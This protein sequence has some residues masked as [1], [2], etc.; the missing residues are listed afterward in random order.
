MCYA[1][2]CYA[3]LVCNID[4]KSVAS[5]LQ[6]VDFPLAS[7]QQVST[8]KSPLCLLCCF[9]SQIPLQRLVADKLAASPSKGKLRG[10]V[11]NGL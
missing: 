10:N 9:V 8:G 5:L 2:L 1:M 7:P 6:V 3:M 11:Y 4:D